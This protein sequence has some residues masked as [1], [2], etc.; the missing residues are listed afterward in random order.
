MVCLLTEGTPFIRI[1]RFFCVD[2][3]YLFLRI[4]VMRYRMSRKYTNV[5]Y[6]LNHLAQMVLLML[7]FILIG[8]IIVTHVSR[9]RTRNFTMEAHKVTSTQILNRVMLDPC[10]Y[11]QERVHAFDKRSPFRFP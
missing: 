5:Y 2:Y 7:L 10:R 11:D 6:T 1:P 4:P 9:W 3:V 8:K